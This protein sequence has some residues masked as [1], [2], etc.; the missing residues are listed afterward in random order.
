MVTRGV[1][2]VARS[3][4]PVVRKMLPCPTTVALRAVALG[5]IH[6]RPVTPVEQAVHRLV[7]VQVEDR[8]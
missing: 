1:P 6:H 4:E 3:T 7:S 2:S 8:Q 5:G